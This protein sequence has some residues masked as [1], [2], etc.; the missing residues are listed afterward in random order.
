[1]DLTGAGSIA[2]LGDDAI[3]LAELIMAEREPIRHARMMNRL[4]EVLERECLKNKTTPAQEVALSCSGLNDTQQQ[5]IVA[6]LQDRMG[7]TPVTSNA[8][9]GSIKETVAKFLAQKNAGK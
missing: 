7:L 4:V 6:I 5:I 3:K 2:G 8:P 9:A 1:M